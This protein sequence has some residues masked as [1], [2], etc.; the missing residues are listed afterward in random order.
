M[1][2]II[3]HNIPSTR[4]ELNSLLVKQQVI[5]TQFSQKMATLGIL[6]AEKYTCIYLVDKT[7]GSFVSSSWEK[8]IVMVMNLRKTDPYMSKYF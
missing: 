6:V 1:Q 8:Y 2:Y 4:D 5:F 3:S 7:L